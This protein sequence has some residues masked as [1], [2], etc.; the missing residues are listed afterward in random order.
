[1]KRAAAISF[2]LWAFA[3]S[4]VGHTRTVEDRRLAAADACVLPDPAATY[5]ENLDALPDVIRADLLS[6][7][8]AM[9]ARNEPF[10]PTDVG[11][12]ATAGLPHH[13]FLRAAHAGL[14]WMIW[15]EHGGYGDHIHLAVYVLGV[16]G[17]DPSPIASLS[18]NLVGPPCAA[19]QAVLSGVGAATFKDW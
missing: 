19:A 17:S 4:G 9:A 15:Y 10:N 7:T 18:A 13:R 14:R 16:R 3:W 11:T 1:M 6:H 5:F 12:P 8:G 2:A